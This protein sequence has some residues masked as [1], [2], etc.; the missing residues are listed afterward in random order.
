MSH[1]KNIST[2]HCSLSHPRNIHQECQRLS[3]M[4]R[5]LTFIFLFF[6]FPTSNIQW[7]LKQHFLEFASCMLL[8]PVLTLMIHGRDDFMLNGI[9]LFHYVFLKQMKYYEIW[10]Y[11]LYF[12]KKKMMPWWVNNTLLLAATCPPVYWWI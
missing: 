9:L 12:W 7:M 10:N 1:K 8:E 4:K 2:N 3:I 5:T 6:L 11:S